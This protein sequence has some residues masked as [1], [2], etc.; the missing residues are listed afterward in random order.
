ME[1]MIF[2]D[3]DTNDYAKER[4]MLER[5]LNNAKA[6]Y[7]D[8]NNLRAFAA[9]KKNKEDLTYGTNHNNP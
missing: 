1:E 5:L 7:N 3:I 8:P 2:A 4:V 9:W 6:I